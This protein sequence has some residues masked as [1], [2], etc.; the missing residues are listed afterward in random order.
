M[1][2]RDRKRARGRPHEALIAQAGPRAGKRVAREGRRSTSPPNVPSMRRALDAG[3][4]LEASTRRTIFR[5]RPGLAHIQ[6]L[7]RR[8]LVVRRLSRRMR[9]LSSE[10]LRR[11]GSR[12]GNRR[13]VLTGREL[14]L[15]EVTLRARYPIE[16]CVVPTY[17]PTA[18]NRIRAFYATLRRRGRTGWGSTA[19]CRARASRV[20]RFARTHRTL[21]VM[22]DALERID[23]GKKAIATC[24]C[25]AHD[26]LR[27]S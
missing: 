6:S 25:D 14:Q 7:A 12:H 8:G 15:G 21:N 17:D 19:T 2:H 3:T 23:V 16:R 24:R 9:A 20:R 5:R 18:A 13:G 1:P 10:F 4:H 11:G 26:R 22:H 27:T